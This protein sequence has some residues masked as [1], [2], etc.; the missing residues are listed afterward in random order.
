MTLNEIKK[1]IESDLNEQLSR[2]G[3]MYRL[4]G[5]AK[6]IRSLKHKM[7]IKGEKYRSG[8]DK[9]QDVIGL[10]IVLYFPEDV[11]LLSFFFMCRNLVDAAI[12]ELNPSTFRPQRLNLVKNI[13]DYLVN[14]FRA[15]LPE[16]F[17]TYIDDTYEVQIRTV[18][19]EGWHEVEHD[20]RYKCKEDWE[21]YDS[22]SRKL[23]GII[24]TLETAEFGMSSIFNELSSQYLKDRKFSA[25][26]RNKL[27]IR[28]ANDNFSPKVEDFLRRNPQVAEEAFKMDRTVF[29]LSLLNHKKVLNLT[30][31]NVL[32]L[33][34]R[35]DMFNE[36]LMNLED[37][38]T[39]RQLKDFINS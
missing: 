6:S 34:N 2:C 29:L 33:F 24:A 32:F 20:M 36:E 28:L 23:N 5:R 22:Y 14:E 21:G 11:D 15:A 8:K 7:E 4:F 16:E 18:F 3:L 39:K 37:A 38:D 25:M 17:A 26:L 30:F 12:D 9:I 19:S 31:D 10:R 35:I 13:P 27:R 1:Q